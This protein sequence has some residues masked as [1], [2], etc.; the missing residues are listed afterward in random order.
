MDQIYSCS[1]RFHDIVEGFNKYYSVK[2]IISSLFFLITFNLFLLNSSLINGYVTS[3][4]HSVPLLFWISSFFIFALSSF[5]LLYYNL[6]TTSV[7]LLV[8]AIL[9]NNLILLFSPYLCGIYLMD[10]GDLPTHCG[11]TLDIL[12]TTRINFKI[13][14]YPLTHILSSFLSLICNFSYVDSTKYIAPIFSLLSPLFLSALANKITSNKKMKILVFLLGSTFYFSFIVQPNTITTPSGVSK[15]MI[16][17]LLYVFLCRDTDVA[18]SVCFMLLIAAYIIFH[19]LSNTIMLFSLLIFAFLIKILNLSTKANSLVYF[20]TAFITYLVFLTQIWKRPV[21]NIAD[22]LC[23]ERYFTDS[24]AVDISGNLDKLQ[25]G[26]VDLLH[27]FI[28]AFGHQALLLSMTVFSIFFALFDPKLRVKYLKENWFL[29]ILSYSLIAGILLISQVALP[30]F[31]NI[32][33]G[34]FLSYLLVFTPLISSF[35][36][37]KVSQKEYNK[38]YVFLILI[39]IF[40]NSV[41]VI[42]PSPYIHKLNTQITQSEYS[43]VN[44]IFNHK[45]ADTGLSGYFGAK[46]TTRLISGLSPFNEYYA[47]RYTKWEDKNQWIPDNFGYDETNDTIYKSLQEDRYLILTEL[48]VVAYTKVYNGVIERISHDSIKKLNQDTTSSLIYNNQGYNIYAV[49]D[50]KF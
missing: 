26:G 43:G 22:F 21:K 20:F 49:T 8:F 45:N 28:K 41:L 7:I 14:P 3:F 15:F 5:L 34:R 11:M 29:F 27:F 37:C 39:F 44:W 33:F 19:P 35:F 48:D 30:T 13:N 9:F 2:I 18:F 38:K 10:N 31:L 12:E 47:A 4:Y 32:S 25:L 17:L 50:G 36:L 42:Y 6:S 16:P 23:G 40:I 1:Y 46:A 24:Y